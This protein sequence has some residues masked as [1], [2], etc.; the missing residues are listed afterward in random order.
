MVRNMRSI[1]LITAASAYRFHKSSIDDIRYQVVATRFSGA[2]SLLSR[3]E[4]FQKRRAHPLDVL[5][6]KERLN[7]LAAG[8]SD[9]PRLTMSQKHLVN[10]V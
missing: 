2:S 4:I 8:G 5:Q 3:L 7:F 10:G 6:T 1:C 9:D